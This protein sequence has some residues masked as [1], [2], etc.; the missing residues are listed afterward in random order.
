M[1]KYPQNPRRFSLTYT[2]PEAKVYIPIEHA[3]MEKWGKDR[4]SVHQECI[5]RTWNLLQQQS[6]E[7][8]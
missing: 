8:V 7:L 6:V 2:E 3:L 4:G 1:A 5:K